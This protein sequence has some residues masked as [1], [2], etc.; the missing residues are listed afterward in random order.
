MATSRGVRV[1]D[2][3]TWPLFQSR[4]LVQ[5]NGAGDGRLHGLEDGIELLRSEISALSEPNGELPVVLFLLSDDG[6]D[7]NLFLLGR[8]D[9]LGEPLSA[10][11]NLAANAE[12]VGHLLDLGAV[13]ANAVDDGNESQLSG[14]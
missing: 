7:G 5:L 9:R 10:V 11:V 8:S 1:D 3:I 6:D 12:L 2:G 14:S 13:V 4:Y